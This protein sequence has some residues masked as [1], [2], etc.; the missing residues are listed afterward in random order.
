[1]TSADGGWGVQGVGAGQRC[2]GVTGDRGG[3]R[4]SGG[5]WM[6]EGDG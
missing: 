6:R 1:M 4:A 2:G 5:G 3:W